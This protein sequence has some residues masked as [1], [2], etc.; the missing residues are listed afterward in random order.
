MPDFHQ[1]QLAFEK[2]TFSTRIVIIKACLVS[3]LHPIEHSEN[4][5]IT[6][7]GLFENEIGLGLPAG[8]QNEQV[9]D[10]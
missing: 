1:N 3:K 10:H 5:V 6:Q 2:E 4:K 7:C 9:V 8:M